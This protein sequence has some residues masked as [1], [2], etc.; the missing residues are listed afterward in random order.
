VNGQAQRATDAP[1]DPIVSLAE[2]VRGKEGVRSGQE[3]PREKEDAIS[4]AVQ[5]KTKAETA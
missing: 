5:N 3:K 4:K 2:P 1:R